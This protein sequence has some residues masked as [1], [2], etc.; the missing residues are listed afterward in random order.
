MWVCVLPVCVFIDAYLCE[1]EV[2]QQVLLDAPLVL[3]VQH[4]LNITT[5]GLGDVVHVLRLDHRLQV[6]LKH[7]REVVLRGEGGGHKRV[8][9]ETGA[10]QAGRQGSGWAGAQIE[11]GCHEV[12]M[13][14]QLVGL[15][16]TTLLIAAP[17]CKLRLALTCCPLS[18][19]LH[20]LPLPP[21]VS[22][23]CC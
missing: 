21:L 19:S 14:C 1:V 12:T 8:Q 18:P 17:A 11:V 15:K 16:C 23:P 7:T 10:G 20:P 9:A 22:A 13:G 4:L 6:V 5:H 3:A 2:V